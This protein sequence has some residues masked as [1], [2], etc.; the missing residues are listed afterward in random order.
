LEWTIFED[1]GD[2]MLAIAIVA[3][4]TGLVLGL[5]FS[6]VALALLIITTTI[7]FAVCMWGGSGP[8]VGTLQL[9]ATLASVQI[10]YLV[11]CLLA[12]HIPARAKVPS[13]RKQMRYVRDWST[14]AV[15]LRATRQKEMASSRSGCNYQNLF[16]LSRMHLQES[17]DG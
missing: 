7:V 17:V 11:G 9:L 16:R 10:S 6:L 2:S 1:W 4:A 8:L 3:A 13:S 12:A 15:T 5:R 14:R